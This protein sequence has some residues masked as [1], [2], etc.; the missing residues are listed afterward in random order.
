[1]LP[2]SPWEMALTS[3]DCL[4][5][6]PWGISAENRRQNEQ[7]SQVIWKLFER[8]KQVAILGEDNFPAQRT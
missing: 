4:A 1:M 6:S 7:Q 3:A 2:P 8:G 5:G